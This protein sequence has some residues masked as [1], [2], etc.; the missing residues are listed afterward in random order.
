MIYLKTPE[1]MKQMQAACELVSRT[2]GEVARWI[3][4]GVTTLKVDTIAR[5]FIHDNGG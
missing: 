4:P 3:E 1:D 2:M 5:E